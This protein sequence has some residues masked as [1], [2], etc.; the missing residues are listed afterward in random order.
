VLTSLTRLLLRRTLRTA[1]ALRPG[2]RRIAVHVAAFQALEPAP[3]RVVA[4]LGPPFD[5]DAKRTFGHK[6]TVAQ[7]HARKFGKSPIQCPQTPQ[8][9]IFAAPPDEYGGGLPIGTR[10]ARLWYVAKDRAMQSIIVRCSLL[11]SLARQGRRS[12]PELGPARLVERDE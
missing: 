5:D 11:S 6:F 8:D 2:S 12:Y 7:N 9:A 10:A 1:S 3:W 4:T